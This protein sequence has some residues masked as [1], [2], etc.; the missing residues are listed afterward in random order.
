MEDS[1]A[2]DEGVNA[3]VFDLQG[4]RLGQRDHRELARRIGAL[5]VYV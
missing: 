2:D 5:A 4:D 1:G 3:E